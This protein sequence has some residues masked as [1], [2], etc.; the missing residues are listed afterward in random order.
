M[1][2]FNI[3]QF[4]IDSLHNEEILSDR[5]SKYHIETDLVDYLEWDL[6]KTHLKPIGV[7]SGYPSEYTNLI[8]QSNML[9]CVAKCSFFCR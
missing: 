6:V 8:L 2:V 5:P 7:G 9:Y 4:A 3:N 1:F